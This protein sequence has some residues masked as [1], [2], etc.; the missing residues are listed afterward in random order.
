MRAL[1][2]GLAEWLEIE[3]ESAVKITT[4]LGHVTYILL[5]ITLFTGRSRAQ[6]SD[7]TLPPV[8]TN[9]AQ[10]RALGPA[11]AQNSKFPVHVRGVVTY[12]HSQRSHFFLQDATAGMLIPV[13]NA[14][15]CP[16]FATEVEVRGVT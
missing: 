2:F 15:L 6:V 5:A 1:R 4:V 13:T 16:E 3:Y 8:L 7:D 14:N 10:I 9:L 12:V 11:K